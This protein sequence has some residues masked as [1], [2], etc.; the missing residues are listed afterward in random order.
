[1]RAGRHVPVAVNLSA[2]NLLDRQL[3]MD[4]GGVLARYGLP[5]E[6]LVLEITETTMMSELDVVESVLGQ[7]RAMGVQLSVDDFGTGYSSLAF[8]QRV[9]V[10]EVK[11]DRSFVSGLGQSENDRALV[12]ATVQLAHSLGA[13][14]IG[15]GVE[16]AGQL[17]V[18]TE[19]GC[20]SAQGYHLGRPVPAADVRPLLGLDA[21]GKTLP[22][23][24]DESR[25]L[26]AVNE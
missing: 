18:L 15:E 11:I 24:R 23:P 22:L 19:L 13:R 14:C 8:L 16:T 2:R 9:Q 6:L 5:P 20:D 26:R 1:M 10:N 12:R 25:H 21:T 17:A 4:V 7:L 3:P